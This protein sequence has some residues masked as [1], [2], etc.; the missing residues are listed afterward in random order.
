MLLLNTNINIG[1]RPHKAMFSLS[2]FFHVSISSD[3]QVQIIL[4]MFS[5]TFIVIE[6]VL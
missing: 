2:L 5:N 3:L 1:Q 4:E 6:Y